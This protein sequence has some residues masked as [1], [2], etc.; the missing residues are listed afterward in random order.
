M[1]KA[2]FQS[3][4]DAL[5]E[6]GRYRHFATLERQCGKFTWPVPDYISVPQGNTGTHAGADIAA[7]AGS[8]VMAA[9]DGT[10]TSVAS[11]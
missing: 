7:L 9:R 3:K 5:K 6:E 8:S 2:F 1:D 4:I 10:V 11:P